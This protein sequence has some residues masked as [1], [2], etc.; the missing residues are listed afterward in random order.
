MSPAARPVIEPGRYRQR[1]ESAAWLAQAAG[2]DALLIGVGADLRYLTGYPAM[3]LERL[4]MLVV[5]ARGV[6][7]LMAPRLEI[8][9]ARSCPA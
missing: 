7:F 2:L 6:A 5:P 4:T 8:S 3:A 1:I 9:S